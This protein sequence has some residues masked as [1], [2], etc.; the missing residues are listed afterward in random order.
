MTGST[1][2]AS[3]LR[4]RPRDM[5]HSTRVLEAAA[6]LL[7]DGGVAACTIEA[8]SKRSGVSKPTMYRRWPNRSVLAVDAF[9]ARIARQV[10][11]TETGDATA[12]LIAAVSAIAEQ[13]CGRDG[14][15]FVEL[16]A[17]A[18]LE[19]GTADLLNDRFFAPR[20]AAIRAVWKRGVD[21]GQLDPRVDGDLMVDLLVGPTA[22]RMILGRQIDHQTTQQLARA[23]LRGLTT[24][25]LDDQ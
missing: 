4:G 2:E 1:G 20:R 18:V 9:A 5:T 19:P 24:A 11:L 7:L 14:R 3:G 21:S 22:F 25:S 13:Y 8:V 12:D 16:L 15:I 6:Q 10:P 23:A 17:A